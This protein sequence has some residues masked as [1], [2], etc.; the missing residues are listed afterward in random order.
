MVAPPPGA[1]SSN[2]RLSPRVGYRALDTARWNNVL[3]PHYQQLRARG[4]PAKV[5]SIA[6]ARKLVLYLNALLRPAVAPAA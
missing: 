1:C 2:A 3:R 4:K 6:V 5:A